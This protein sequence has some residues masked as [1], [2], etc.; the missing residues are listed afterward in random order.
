MW[1]VFAILSLILIIAVII[2][3]LIIKSKNKK[4]INQNNQI[5]NLLE[6]GK[7]QETKIEKLLEEM[8]IEKNHNQELA[9][10][11]ADISCMSIDDVMHQLQND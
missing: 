9:K 4:I 11:L 3:I 1:K 6:N 5:N 8:Q 7:E 10:K 2:L